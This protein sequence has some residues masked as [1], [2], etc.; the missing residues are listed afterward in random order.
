MQEVFK[1]CV[2]YKFILSTCSDTLDS[3]KSRM[4]G[5][6]VAVIHTDKNE[7]KES[8]TP[9]YNRLLSFFDQSAKQTPICA[10]QKCKKEQSNA[11]HS[12]RVGKVS[13]L[14]KAAKASSYFAATEARPT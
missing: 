6:M 4:Q 3:I 10:E 11:Q 8:G 7:S 5:L 9:F 1:A 14:A 13:K 2:R 12:Q